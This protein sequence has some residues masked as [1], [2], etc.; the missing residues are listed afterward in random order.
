MVFTLKLPR[1]PTV[2]RCGRASF[3]LC[4]NETTNG[5]VSAALP[6]IARETTL[7]VHEPRQARSRRRPGLN[8]RRNIREP[9]IW[10]KRAHAGPR[11]SLA[12]TRSGRSG[13][14]PS[15]RSPLA[16]S[17]SI[18]ASQADAKLKPRVG[19]ACLRLVPTRSLQV[20]NQT[21]WRRSRA[22]W[23]CWFPFPHCTGARRLGTRPRVE[24]GGPP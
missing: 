8:H 23:S 2:R 16:A 21:H 22:A 1:M 11:C 18:S 7:H 10:R 13:G 19:S 15:L 14:G 5:R 12:V 20:R 6:W 24:C 17:L 9:H 4:H 3:E